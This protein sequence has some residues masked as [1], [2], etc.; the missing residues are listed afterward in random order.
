MLRSGRDL[1]TV[2]ESLVLGA[3]EAG[4]SSCEVSEPSAVATG[5]SEMLPLSSA[6]SCLLQP[7]PSL[8]YGTEE[9]GKCGTGVWHKPW[10]VPEDVYLHFFCIMLCLAL[11]NA[12]MSESVCLSPVR[13]M[14][15]TGLSE[16]LRTNMC[17]NSTSHYTLYRDVAFPKCFSTFMLLLF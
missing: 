7:P 13:G 9:L 17:H 15:D 16:T 6:A 14:E 10:R 4:R 1:I 2:L 8:K 12:R 5:A 3:G 11:M